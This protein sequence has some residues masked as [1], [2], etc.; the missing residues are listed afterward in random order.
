MYVS[1]AQISKANWLLSLYLS[2]ETFV[3]NFTEALL[4]N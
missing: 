4:L 2:Q 1:V 3:C